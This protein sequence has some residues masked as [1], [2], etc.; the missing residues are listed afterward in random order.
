[1]FVPAKVGQKLFYSI[2]CA[3]PKILLVIIKYVGK[4]WHS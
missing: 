4:V 2:N 1:M 3:T